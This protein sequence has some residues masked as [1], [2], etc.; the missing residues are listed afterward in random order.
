VL[1]AGESNVIQGN[2][3]GTDRHGTAPLGNG[4]GIHSF[5]IAD[6][7]VVGGPDPGDRNVISGNTIDGISF[8]SNSIE[9]VIQGNFIGT[10]VT[11]THDLGNGMDGIFAV[12]GFHTISGNLI[13]G[14][15]S[16]GMA[17]AGP[18]C[19][20][21]GNFIG[22]DVTGTQPLGNGI[23][24]IFLF[25]DAADTL[26]G[27]TAPGA[28]NTIAFNGHRGIWIDLL[29]ATRNAIRRNSI[30]RNGTIGIELGGD[31]P[32]P[33]D[34]GDADT[35]PNALQNFPLLRSVV[36]DGV[37]TTIQGAFR[38]A[39][40]ETLTL[41][42]FSNP[43]NFRPRALLQGQTYLGDA[44][45]TTDATGFA[46][47]DVTLPVGTEAGAPVSA[48]ATDSLGDTSEFAQQIV[49]GIVPASGPGAG[50]TPVTISG[51]NFD[52]GVAVTIGGAAPGSVARV[53][54]V[55]ITA[56]APAL[57]PGS[58]ND[59]VVTNPDT[60]TGTLLKG[61]VADFLDVPDSHQFHDFVTTL[62][63]N[64]VTVGCGFGNY[65]VDNPTTRAHMAVFLLKALLGFCFTPPPATGTVFADVPQ[66]SIYAP[67]IEE[68][69]R[70]G[71]T[72]GCGGGNYCPDASVTRAQ[73]A[74]FLLNTAYGPGYVPPPATG[75]AFDD[76]PAGSFA[77]DWIEDLV[78]RGITAGC[79]ASPPLYCPANPITRGQ[80]ATFIVITFAL[81]P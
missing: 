67:W 18:S 3:L 8:G 33:N 76:V 43:C 14:N 32:T 68:L 24:G 10:D 34:D 17:I 6:R 51:T 25:S 81:Q 19:L 47:V 54:D 16:S 39:P 1:D 74:V 9:H 78:A 48:T 41:E 15:G 70:R 13:S 50:G 72:A 65:C 2:F 4:A 27:G 56:V 60:T 42:F 49:F 30:Y 71:L 23:N 69:A 5:D 26:I 35:G 57:P 12:G 73:M 46:A 59:V 79:S 31:G 22:T 28:G 44:Q 38:G 64:G 40:N 61:W 58:L 55:Q 53:S 75:T 29:P 7:M 11:G 36:S 63:S 80:M 77:A 21:Q 66:T 37:T 52:L 45:I 62:V 20:I